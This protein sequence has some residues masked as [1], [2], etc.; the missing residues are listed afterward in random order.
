MDEKVK[1]KKKLKSCPFCGENNTMRYTGRNILTGKFGSN[2][3]C[4]SCWASS[5]WRD[6]KEEAVQ[7]WEERAEP[8]R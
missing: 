8:N 1:E 7:A 4:K 6:T 3:Y 2:V 5:G